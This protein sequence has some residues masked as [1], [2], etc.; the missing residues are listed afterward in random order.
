MGLGRVQVLRS[1]VLPSGEILVV[2]AT[3]DHRG[4]GEPRSPRLLRFD[5]Q[6]RLL[7]FQGVPGVET[8][9][10]SDVAVAHD[11]RV[12]VAGLAG[13]ADCDVWVAEIAQ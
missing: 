5:P 7:S 9:S 4:P 2:G 11:G 6:G 10:A 8:G 1:A 3:P 12:Y 13:D